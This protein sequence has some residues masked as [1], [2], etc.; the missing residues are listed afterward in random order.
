MTVA[1]RSVLVELAGRF[2]RP[3]FHDGPP[4]R[5]GDFIATLFQMQRDVLACTARKVAV[6]CTRRAGKTTLVPAALFAAA[7][8]NPGCVVLF[9]GRTRIRAKQL[10]WKNL[11]EANERYRLGYATNASELTLTHP[12]NGAEIRLFGATDTNT[13]ERIRGDKVAFVII[14]ETQSVAEDVLR[15][16]I[17]DVLWPALLDVSGRLVMLGTPGYVCAGYWYEVTRN[18][19]AKS[20]A[21]RA[22]GW[23]VY[24]WSGLDNPSVNHKGQRICDLFREELESLEADPAKGPSH[25]SV[26]REYRGRWCNDSEGLFYAFEP[27]RNLYEGELPEGHHWRYVMGV[28][29]GKAAFAIEV[30]A[31]AETHPVIYEVDGLKEH[32]V[33]S[34]RWQEATVGFLDRWQPE[35]CV[36]DYGGLGAA[37]IDAWREDGL[38]VE[39]AEKSNRDAFVALLNG[40]LENGAVKAR[41]GGPLAGEWAVLP[42]DPDS[43]PA[44]PPQPKPGFDDHS[45]DAGLYAW[46][47]AR[48]RCGR[49]DRPAPRPGTP[50]A[51][52]LEM[53]QQKAAFLERQRRQTAE[54]TW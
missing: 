50:A 16:L 44:K 54:E 23:A 13:P 37:V 48:G 49:E 4:A 39:Y 22:K 26:V 35:A 7:E 53:K 11:L 42:K 18:E 24:E 33:N 17:D 45:S 32:R 20:K 29:L 51:Q 46:R 38:P 10:A 8:E 30:L 15:T 25:P 1:L 43:P 9:I 31:F 6:L 19:D 27:D 47:T 14:D 40:E 12:T 34:K 5:L 41:K 28:D 36:V 2:H 3:K 52:A 21:E